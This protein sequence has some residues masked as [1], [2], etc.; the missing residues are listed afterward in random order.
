MPSVADMGMVWM[1]SGQPSADVPMGLVGGEASEMLLDHDNIYYTPSHNSMSNHSMDD[2][3]SL[4]GS[5]MAS[6]I[7]NVHNYIVIRQTTKVLE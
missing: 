5:N 4:H 3:H 6:I 1:G 7:L 2:M